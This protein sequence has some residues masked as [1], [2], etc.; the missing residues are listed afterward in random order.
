MAYTYYRTPEGAY[1]GTS[2]TIPEGCV[3]VTHDEVEAAGKPSYA[4]LRAMAYP[5]V[6]D[7]ADAYYWQQQGDSTKME[8]YLAK[9][10]EV[11]A[12]YPKQVQ[13]VA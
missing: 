8:A 2:T 7:F 1:F 11:K 12:A 10:A 5:S 6:A 13:G 3:E 4:Q 9:L